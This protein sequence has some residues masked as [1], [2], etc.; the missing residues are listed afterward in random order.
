MNHKNVFSGLFYVILA[1]VILVVGIQLSFV[2]YFNN[3]IK[4]QIT[5]SATKQSNGEYEVTIEKLNTNLFT[6]SIYLKGFLLKPASKSTGSDAKYFASAS[7]ISLTNLGI[8]SFLLNK[9][10][11][12]SGIEIEDPSGYIYRGKT[13]VKSNVT[14][15]SFHFSIY[16]IISKSISAV[17]I[18]TIKVTNADLRIYN[19]IIDT[20][21]IITS[22]DNRIEISELKIDKN[23]E[24]AGRMFFANRVAIIMNRFSY[25]TK[26]SLYSIKVK[27][28][29][30][31]YTDSTLTIDSVEVQPNYSKRQF[32]HEAGKQTDRM[33]VVA[34]HLK[35][36]KMDV[37]QLFE[38][39]WFV[40]ENLQIDS[41][42]LSA[43]RDKNLKREY[44]R[45][46]SVQSLLA[47]IPIYLVIDS[48]HMTNSLITY[49]EVAEG[50]SAA[51]RISFNNL[52]ATLTGVTSDT[53]LFSKYA[54]LILNG[55]GKF[56]NEANIQV[57]YSFPLTATDMIFDCSGSLSQ[58]KME[59]I[60]PMLKPNANIAM[61][62]GVIDSMFF[63]FHANDK[64]AKGTMKFAYHNL[65][66]EF[67][68]KKDKKS[69]FIEDALAFLVHKLILK[70]NNPSPGGKL[71]ITEI[72][73]TRNPE[74][75]IFNY[76]WKSIL[77]GIKPA[78]GLPDGLTKKK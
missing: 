13:R 53:T 23:T 47:S 56:M 21:P 70:E 26:D 73:Y 60:N 7:K 36:N 27:Q 62:A 72:N 30:A 67:L 63:A 59:S 48:V 49:E 68:N 76:T 61:K 14:D 43:Y 12:I 45:P 4:E 10:I 34:A 64:V 71:R 29:S 74:R 44:N 18:S 28:L 1:I 69:G 78:I 35:F 55:K 22:K 2:F 42:I 41:L 37:K 52:D 57:N 8:I 54:T 9:E 19:S 32:S 24:L 6:Q 20:V 11:N 25:T 15:S 51:G 3:L 50:A 33:N 66:L 65:D 77:S 39:N 16:K 40:A 46:E 58:M 38:R 5:T 17:N 75:F 31:S